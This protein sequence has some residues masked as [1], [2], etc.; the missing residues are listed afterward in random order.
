MGA[1]TIIQVLESCSEIDRDAQEE[2]L[3]R[4]VE[5]E[6]QKGKSADKI[7]ASL[8]RKGFSLPAIRGVLKTFDSCDGL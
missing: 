8:A 4:L 1:D 7:A 6:T 5:R 2:K 3:R